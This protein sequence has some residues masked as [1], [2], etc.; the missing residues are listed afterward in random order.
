[1][2]LY[3]ALKGMEYLSDMKKNKEKK[4]QFEK[5]AEKTANKEET[6]VDVFESPDIYSLRMEEKAGA[7]GKRTFTITNT[8]DD[9]LYT[10]K[11]TGT[12]KYPYLKL[13]NTNDEVVGS[14]KTEWSD[15]KPLF[16]LNI[17]GRQCQ[18]KQTTLTK[19]MYE[20]HGYGWQIKSQIGKTIVCDKRWTKIIQIEWEGTT[21]KG[22]KRTDVY[23][24][25][26]LNR[27]DE[28]AALVVAL[29]IYISRRPEYQ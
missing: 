26:I 8:A 28:I 9:V 22:D 18:L 19:S 4:K 1:M 6:D 23:K 29:A 7:F 10:V 24:V 16:N 25:K 2:G 13:Y 5:V 14:V 21:L 11:K 15:Y 17:S 3:K 12:F 27:N 20:L